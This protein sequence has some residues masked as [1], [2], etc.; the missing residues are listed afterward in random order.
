M[1]KSLRIEAMISDPFDDDGRLHVR[2]SVH[3]HD[4]DSE[5]MWLRHRAV[6]I[7][8]TGAASVQ[9]YP[10]SGECRRLASALL[11]AAATFSQQDDTLESEK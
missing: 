5:H 9:V 6:L 10:T 1:T 7:V 11:E 2:L 3:G 4:P 8:A